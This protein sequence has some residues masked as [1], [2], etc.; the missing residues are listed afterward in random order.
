MATY[1]SIQLSN[2]YNDAA[3]AWAG[4]LGGVGTTK[5]YD[6]DAQTTTD[7]VDGDIVLNTQDTNDIFNGNGSWYYGVVSGTTTYPAVFQVDG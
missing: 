4:Q 6:E 7:L 3:S 2:N 1:V 5:Y